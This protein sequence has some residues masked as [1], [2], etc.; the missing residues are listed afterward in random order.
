MEKQQFEQL[1]KLLKEL[2]EHLEHMCSR[3]SGIDSSLET[4]KD[5]IKKKRKSLFDI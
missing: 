1:E 4:L 2:N 3:L 5:E